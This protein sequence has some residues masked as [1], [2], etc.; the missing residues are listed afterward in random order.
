M[1]WRHLSKWAISIAKRMSFPLKYFTRHDTLDLRR[2]L[3]DA[4]ARVN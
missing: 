1:V 4:N 3:C 2:G